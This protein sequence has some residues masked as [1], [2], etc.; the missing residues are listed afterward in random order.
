MTEY[1]RALVIGCG[2]MG[3]GRDLVSTW[4]Y[5]HAS[6]YRT[7]ADRVMIVGFVDRVLVRAEWA[8]ARCGVPFAGDNVTAA[9]EILQPDI[10]SI[11]TPPSDREEIITACDAAPSVHGIWCEKP[12]YLTRLPRAITQVNYIRRFD[13]RHQEI[14]RRRTQDNRLADLFV[15]AAK[16]IHLTCHFGDLARFW[17][18]PLSR[19]HYQHFHGPLLYV[20]RERG[21]KPGRYAGWRD[22]VFVGGGMTTGFM[23][24]ALGNLLDAVEGTA[25]PLSSAENAIESERWAEA[26]R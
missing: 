17:Q 11:C 5:D 23:E 16:D 10:V 7:L 6:A 4:L 24:R 2:R 15:F 22:D 13:L 1:H 9:L 26:I 19:L 25:A 12:Y 20:L 3:C 21:D 14:A 8:A 18:I